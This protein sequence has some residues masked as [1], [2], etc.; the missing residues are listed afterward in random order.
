MIRSR[1]VFRFLLVVAAAIVLLV[2]PASVPAQLQSKDQQKCLIKAHRNFGKQVEAR[3]EQACDC[4]KS[5]ARGKADNLGRG[6]TAQ[7]CLTSDAGKVAKRDEKTRRD[8]DR[9]CVGL[10]KKGETKVPDFGLSDPESTRRFSG[11]QEVGII[12]ALFGSDLDGALFGEAGDQDASKCQQ[13]VARFAKR[14]QD[15]R[16]REFNTC[17]KRGLEDGSITDGAGLEACIGKDDNGRIARACNAGS[18]GSKGADKLGRTVDKRCVGQSVDLSDAF[19]PCDTDDPDE[20]HEC[21]DTGIECATCLALNAVGELRRDCDELDNGV[22]DQSCRTPWRVEAPEDQDMDAT[23][24]DGARAYAFQ[25]G[26]NTQGVVV[27]RHGVIV[28]EWYEPGRDATSFATSWSVAKSFTSALIG[29]AIDEGLID[30]VHVSMAEFFPSWRGTDKE[31]ITLYDVLAMASGLQWTESYDP[32][33]I[34]SSDIIQMI[35]VSADQLDYAVSRPVDVP[36]GTRFNYS[37]GDTMLLS[38]VLEV[39]TGGRAASYAQ[40]K[41]FDPIGMG[42]VEWW[43]DAADHTV[44]YCCLDTPT[45]QLAKF[46]LLYLNDGAWGRRRV[47]PA[48]WV[49][50]STTPSVAGFYGYQWWLG[51]TPGGRDMY[52]ARGH[53]GQYIYVIPDLDLVVVR[54]GHYDKFDGE[55]RADPSLWVRLPSGGLVPGL[56]TLSPGGW[57]DDAFLQPIEDAVLR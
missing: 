55:A 12:Q 41:L 22:V 15:T 17:A 23:T 20:L 24:L 49:A 2:A 33:D 6:G 52:S 35:L 44:T 29:I 10:D 36:P 25:E 11:E 56:G 13:A 43:R 19:P 40:E 16:I 8:F 46:G 47:V 9:F 32:A 5:Y 50:A 4:I 18:S 48:D 1:G 26:K 37:S 53:D 45:R 28:G 34:A 3:G 30:G 14:C 31:A 7:D 51:T 21:I 42:P 38:G 39:V 54:N 27:V 57:S